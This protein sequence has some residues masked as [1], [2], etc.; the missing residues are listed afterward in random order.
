VEENGSKITSKVKYHLLLSAYQFFQIIQANF[1]PGD[2]RGLVN[3]YLEY[4]RQEKTAGEQI[5]FTD[6]KIVGQLAEVAVGGRLIH[7]EIHVCFLSSHG[8]LCPTALP[9]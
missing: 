7:F 6:D 9:V 3:N 5:S 4:Q 1:K 2:T 8:I